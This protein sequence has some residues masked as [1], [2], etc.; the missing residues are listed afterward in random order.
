MTDTTESAPT[1]EDKMQALESR[2]SALEQALVSLGD[3]V[4][5][6]GR[7]ALKNYH[8]WRQSVGE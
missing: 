1:I 5:P 4:S 8:D 7:A 6:G 3:A 2:L